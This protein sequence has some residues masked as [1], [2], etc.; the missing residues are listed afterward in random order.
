MKKQMNK[1]L[2]QTEFWVFLII[3]FLALI[4][5]ARSGA[6]FANN[7]IVDI[8]RSMI[9]P[10]L[11]AVCALLAFVSTGPDVSFPLVA[12]LSSYLAITISIVYLIGMFFGALMGALNGFIIVKYKF[13]SL[14]VTLG[15]SSLFSGILLGTFEAARMDLPATLQRFAELSLLTVKNEKTGLG[16]TLPM[17][18]LI[19]VAVYIAAYLVLN[20]TMVGRGVYAIGGDEISAER[21]GFNVKKIRFGIF[22]VNGMIASI[23]GLCYAVMS[24]RY[25]PNEYAGG[26]MVVIAAIILGGTR[27]TGGIGTLKGCI[28]GT[29]L[30][31]MVTNSLIL[32]G[33]SVYWQ[34]VF[35][36]AIIIIGTAI[37]AIQSIFG[38]NKGK[39]VKGGEAA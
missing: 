3:I 12:A 9:C 2:R 23:A 34:K 35:I 7:N 36:G 1:V 14:I 20:Y 13:P 25:L 31:T 6:F 4:I 38:K 24:M 15:T 19:L 10:S 16:S 18:F 32:V 17:T 30:L 28:L 39:K 22:V 29:L 21:A 8:M 37:P 5:Q 26:E 33:I 11:Y 27:M